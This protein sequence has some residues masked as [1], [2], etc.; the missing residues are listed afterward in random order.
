MEE[1]HRKRLD[2][3]IKLLIAH[4]VVSLTRNQVHVQL[5]YSV[6]LHMLIQIVR[7]VVILMCHILYNCCCGDPLRAVSFV[8]SLC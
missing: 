7:C 6:W 5:W 4:V 2:A 1:L 3:G 8:N